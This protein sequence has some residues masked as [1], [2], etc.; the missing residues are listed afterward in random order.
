MAGHRTRWLSHPLPS[1]SLMCSV[2]GDF[3][4][5]W[6]TGT[7][8]DSY[9]AIAQLVERF[10]GME[11]VGSSILPG[12]TTV[13]AAEGPVSDW[14]LAGFVAG[15]GC[16]SIT[17]KQPSFVNGDPRLRFV[18]SLGV[19]ARDRPL[20]ELLRARLG[21]GS[22]QDERPRRPGWLPMAR[23]SIGSMRAHR[24]AVIPFFD[25]YL[26]GSAK[27]RQFDLWVEAMNSYESYH[28]TRWGR[29]PST[30]RI[31]GCEKPVR[32]RGLCRSHYYS[33]TGY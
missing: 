15:E 14:S 13:G 21:C 1:V 3:A 26:I 19:A 18:F 20:V 5:R 6:S 33:E 4:A 8:N 16:F 11:E 7:V 12:S 27:R 24:G 32:G 25:R 29:G 9:G 23:Y 2:C 31:D 17:T 28:P 22:I 10:H 30:C